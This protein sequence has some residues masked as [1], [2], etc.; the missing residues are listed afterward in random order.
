MASNYT[1]NYK[2]PLWEG[3]D[4]F[5]REE[6]NAAHEDIDAALGEHG[7]AL[8]EHAAALALCGNCKIACGSY[9]GTGTYGEANPCSLTFPFAPSLLLFFTGKGRLMFEHVSYASMEK[10]LIG[11]PRLLS[12]E[13]TIGGFPGV[14]NP[15]S[16]NYH[17]RSPDGTQLM[18]YHE[19]SAK[20]QYNEEGTTYQWVALG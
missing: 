20:L 14:T 5:V 6:F 10:P 17:K 12:T 11:N 19:T 1:T 2:L 15:A 9:V 3:G 8:T 13:Y 7:A 16:D 4:N 18:W